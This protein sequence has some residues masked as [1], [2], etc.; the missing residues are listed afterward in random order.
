MN[1]LKQALGE[2]RDA[3]L[4]R[5]RST[6][7]AINATHVLYNDQPCLLLAGNSYLG[8]THHPAVQNAAAAA[9]LQYGTGS[10][11]SRLTTGSHA[12]Y[13]SLE[14]Q[15]AAFKHSEDAL[16]F[17]SG[18]AAN[19]GVLSALGRKEDVFFSDALNHASLIDGCRQDQ[20]TG[21]LAFFVRDNGAGFDMA[22]AHKLFGVFQRLHHAKE[23]SG[24]GIGL[25]TV[26]R[27][28]H[29]HGGRIWADSQVN[30]GASFF[31]TIDTES[32]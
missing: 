23:F 10:G 17:S 4:L 13:E 1:H 31:F 15:L 29:R 3:H 28:I 18:Y 7:E 26:N 2:L 22:Y 6:C 19:V 11:G 9:A 30:Q 5:R 20:E 16:V 32:K 12:L 8:L 25:A 14:A 21:E 27:I 24:T